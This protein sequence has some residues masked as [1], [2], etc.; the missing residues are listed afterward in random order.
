MIT[1]II[2]ILSLSIIRGLS[3]CGKN[4]VREIKERI[5]EGWYSIDI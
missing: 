4:E 2:V 3:A 5:E 1:F